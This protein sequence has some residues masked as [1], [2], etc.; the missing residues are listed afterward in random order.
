MPKINDRIDNLTLFF[1]IVAIIVETGLLVAPRVLAEEAGASAWLSVIISFFP[2]MAA[3]FL[4]VR[5]SQLFPGEEFT[6]YSRKIIGKWGGVALSLFFASYWIINN[7]RI[8]R[9]FADIIKTTLLFRTPLEIIMLSF[10]IV[11]AYLARGGIKAIARFCVIAFIISIPIGIILV[12]TTYQN[13]D[14]SNLLPIMEKG[15][16]KVI[17][18]GLLVIGQSEGLESILFLLPFVK[19]P[20]KSLSYSLAGVVFA[21]SLLFLVV[22]ATLLNFGV[23]ETVRLTIPGISLIQSAELPGRFLERLGSLYITIWIL[24]VFPTVVAFLYLPSIVLA[25][26]FKLPEPRPFVL[27]LIPLVY[28]IAIIPPNLITVFRLSE[29]MQWIN[30]GAILILPLL[31]YGIARLRG[32]KPGGN[33]C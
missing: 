9:S 10:L 19:K 24:I 17:L 23:T 31:L 14:F 18:A 11:A 20:Q 26:T 12:L 3:A 6:A 29:T 16:P 15:W 21:S 2:A 27:L 13:W 1:A 7:G 8:V 33:G 30:T 25:Q 22:L 5:L 32:L 4:M 28:L